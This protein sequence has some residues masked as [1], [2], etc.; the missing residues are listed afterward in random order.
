MSSGWI[1]YVVHC[2]RDVIGRVG[3][4]SVG[5]DVLYNF[6]KVQYINS[7]IELKVVVFVY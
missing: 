1:H 3:G 2:A 6:T 5:D 7:I 4:S